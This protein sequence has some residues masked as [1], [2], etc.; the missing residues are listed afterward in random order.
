[1]SRG[2]SLPPVCLPAVRKRGRQSEHLS[3]WVSRRRLWALAAKALA[4]ALAGFMAW[5]LVAGARAI[6]PFWRAEW[7]EALTS[8]LLLLISGAMASAGFW[9]AWRLWSDWSAGTV[10]LISGVAIG[11]AVV[12]AW[13]KAHRLAWDNLG[14]EAAAAIAGVVAV[15]GVA[16]GALAYIKLSRFVIGHAELADPRDAH[17][18]PVG[19]MWR[20]KLFCTVLGWSVGWAAMDVTRAL[21]ADV[22]VGGLLGLPVGIGLGIM[23]YKLTLWWLTPPTDAALPPGGFEVLPSRAEGEDAQK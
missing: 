23:T 3:L 16:A 9:I 14:L 18:H 19:H 13:G 11:F 7:A 5:T 1:M 8:I 15:L 12:T 21:S 20:V 2:L 10:R 6:G 4:L 22:G 17:G